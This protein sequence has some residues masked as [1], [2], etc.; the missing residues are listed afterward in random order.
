MGDW[1]AVARDVVFGVIYVFLLARLWRREGGLR[2][3]WVLYAFLVLVVPLSSGS[4]TSF[5]RLGLLAFPLV[6]P[7]AE[8]LGEGG[9]ARRRWTIAA[10]IVVTAL[11]VAQLASQAP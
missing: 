8:W 5:A 7:M 3:P 11:M 4:V 6:W 2:S 1:S 10:A 9:P